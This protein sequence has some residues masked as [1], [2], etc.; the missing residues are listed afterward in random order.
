MYYNY[1][2]RNMERIRNGELL[3]YEFTDGGEFAL[4]LHFSTEP[5]HRPIR[6]HSLWRYEKIL[7]EFSNAT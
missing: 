6:E 2:A 3:S 1:H 5:F 7:K 4:I